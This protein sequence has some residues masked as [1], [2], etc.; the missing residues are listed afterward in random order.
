MIGRSGRRSV[1]V[2]AIGS[3]V[4]STGG[5]VAST[6]VRS[7]QQMAANARA[8]QPS[9]ITA[10]VERRV[11]E[12]TL[13]TRGQVAPATTIEVSPVAAQGA[14]IQVV[15]AVRVRPGDE[16]QVGRVLLAVSG[17][18]V[19]VLAG[20]VPAYRDLKPGDSGP[21]V[22]QAQTAL[23]RLGLDT[24]GDR[25]GVFGPGTKA[26]VRRLYARLGYDVPDTGGLAGRGDLEALD[27]AADA[28]ASVRREVDALRRRIAAD[29]TAE[30]GEQ[31]LAQQLAQAQDRLARAQRKEADLV[32]HTG[33][34]LPLN[35]FVFV[36][37]FPARVSAV[38]ARVGDQVKGSLV[39]IAAGPL[40]VVVKL[41]PDQAALVRP[42]MPAQMTAEMLNQQASGRIEGV[43][44]LT[45]PIAEG[46]A[47]GGTEA[48]YHPM[49]VTSDKPLPAPWSGGDVRVALTAART[50]AAV[51]VVP[52][53]AVSA[54]A[55]GRTSVSVLSGSGAARRI[56]VRAGVSGDGF[57]EVAPVDG[58][59]RDGDRV[60]VSG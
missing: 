24:G 53:S 48:A 49:T 3:A 18:P 35:E 14:T 58:V 56:E 60:V 10:V 52:L 9:L 23:R 57:V 27:A 28:V 45:T 41:R 46:P 13:V 20:A 17:R 12:S 16:V 39:N 15:T 37:A 26:A 19:I 50:T 43:G 55:D 7:P 59:L 6:F 34:M 38:A 8:P 1:L 22:R 42:G 47:E 33:P 29:D 51:Q 5:L 40:Q 44:T 31:P 54:G 11:L 21:D 4:L 25:A 2:V 30:P 36:P 32:A